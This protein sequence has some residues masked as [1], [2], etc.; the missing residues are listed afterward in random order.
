MKGL[1]T[2]F[3]TFLVC[4]LIVCLAAPGQNEQPPASEPTTSAAPATPEQPPTMPPGDL[5]PGEAKPDAGDAGADNA[6]SNLQKQMRELSQK[7][8]QRRRGLYKDNEDVKALQQQISDL[9]Q[10]VNE[11]ISADAEYSKLL[12]EQQTLREQ[13]REHYKENRA[14]GPLEDKARARRRSRES[15]PKDSAPAAEGTTEPVPAPAPEQ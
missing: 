2:L 4:N 10:K 12:A 6:L 9:Q 3:R 13:L 7:I 5:P 14:G 8:N 11:L 15:M 1:V